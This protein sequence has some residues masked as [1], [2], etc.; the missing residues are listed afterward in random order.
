MPTYYY[1]HVRWAEPVVK[2]ISRKPTRLEF[3]R[4]N[5][6]ESHADRCATCEPL[7]YNR[8][9]PYCR[10]GCLLED[11][12][13]RDLKV[14]EDGRVYSTW[15]ED[16]CL[17]RVEVPGQYLAVRALLEQVDGRIYRR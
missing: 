10:R 2:S 7:L 4:M 14:R 8:K 6:L 3:L 5:L 17:V 12:V 16:G 1:P 11:L 15:R 9:P 13:I